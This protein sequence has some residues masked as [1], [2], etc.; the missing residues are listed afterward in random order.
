MLLRRPA[1]SSGSPKKTNIALL[2]MFGTFT[3][4]IL[5][6]FAFS[7]PFSEPAALGPDGF[8]HVR[9]QFERAEASP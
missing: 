5:F 8:R 9:S 6:F 1:D 3:G 2:C 7:N 4:I